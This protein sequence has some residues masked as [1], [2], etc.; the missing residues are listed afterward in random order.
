L[1]HSH[2]F[3][4]V[5]SHS[6]ALRFL[7]EDIQKYKEF[8]P[9]L[10]RILGK[11]PTGGP[12]DPVAI[13]QRIDHGTV[14]AIRLDCGTEDFLLKQNRAFHNH[15]DSLHFAHECQEFPGGHD[16]AYWERHVQDAIEFH[17]RNLKLKRM[18]G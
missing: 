16:W 11:S 2:L 8:C 1:K 6:G 13:A 5:N 15:L 3:A 17:A 18:G 7:P 14:P 10:D 9:E 12:E 4:S